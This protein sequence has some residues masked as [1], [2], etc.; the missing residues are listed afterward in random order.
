M[1]H[2]KG[3]FN[4]LIG[5]WKMCSY[6]TWHYAITKNRKKLLYIVSLEAAK[7]FNLVAHRTIKETLQM[8]VAY[9]GDIYNRSTTVNMPGSEISNEIRP[10]CGVKQ[11]DLMSPS[12]FNMVIDRVDWGRAQ[13]S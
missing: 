12:I 10:Q 9:I 6:W 13:P 1:I 8:M 3:P 5:F 11:D 7:A 2:G 4:S